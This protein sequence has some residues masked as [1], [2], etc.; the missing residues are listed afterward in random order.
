MDCLSV[1]ASIAGVISLAMQ[2]SQ[3][4]CKLIAFL[5][6]VKEAP[7]EIGRLNDLLKLVFGMSASVVNALEYQRKQRGEAAPGNEHLCEV[8][9]ICLKRL[10]PIQHIVDEVEAH[11]TRSNVIAKS[12]IKVKAA[13]KK[14]EI[15]ELERQLGQAMNVLNIMLT[16]SVL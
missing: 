15:M 6:T 2:L 9:I 8:L 10:I 16:T 14:D 5:D 7:T 1:A 12:W 13:L 3:T 4:T 11:Q